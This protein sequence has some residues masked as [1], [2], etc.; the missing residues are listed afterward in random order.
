MV[1]PL[2]NKL[3]TIDSSTF[4]RHPEAI[5]NPEQELRPLECRCSWANAFQSCRHQYQEHLLD[6]DQWGW[7]SE[8]DFLREQLD[9]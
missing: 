7:A 4:N 8:D 3:L 9:Q 6:C 5:V 1:C 2:Q